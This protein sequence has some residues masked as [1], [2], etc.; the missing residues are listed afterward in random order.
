LVPKK[1]IYPVVELPDQPIFGSRQNDIAGNLL[2]WW[3]TQP[4][5]SLVVPRQI[6]AM[7]F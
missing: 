3:C 7:L 5:T 1:K 6:N 2:Y 4:E